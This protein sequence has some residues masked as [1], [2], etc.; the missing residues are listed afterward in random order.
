MEES[1]GIYLAKGLTC[2]VRKDKCNTMN[3][4]EVLKKLRK[5]CRSDQ[6][7]FFFFSK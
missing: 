1:F 3:I 4:K 7:F 5:N 2:A 6:F